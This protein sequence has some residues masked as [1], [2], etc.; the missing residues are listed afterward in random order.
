MVDD[1]LITVAE[2]ARKIGISHT[3][4]GRQIKAGAIRAHGK[5]VRFS[6]VLEDRANNIDA[7]IWEARK[8]APRPAGSPNV[9]A[10]LN[11]VHDVHAHLAGDQA[12]DAEDL[13]DDPVDT[14]VLIDGVALP[15]SKAKA[16]KET[17][18]ARLRKLEFEVKSGSLVEAEAVHRAVFEL[19]RQ[20]RDAWSN[21]PA[22]VSP[23]MASELGVEQVA[24]AVVLEKYVREQLT[25]RSRTAL[26]ITNT[27]NVKPT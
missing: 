21:W 11:D 25:E 13:V 7:S 5:K 27:N 22:R 3:T 19:S 8:K 14:A 1:P 18:L 6:E 4:L 9:H 15:I 20:D 24:L 12:G 17:Y 2:A 16:L 23:L 10:P 26:R